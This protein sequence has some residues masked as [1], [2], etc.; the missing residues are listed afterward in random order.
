MS[1]RPRGRPPGSGGGPKK[2]TGGASKGR[3]KGSTK[4]ITEAHIR[5][6]PKIDTIFRK[7]AIVENRQNTI[8][9]MTVQNEKIRNRVLMEVEQNSKL[10][11][12][13]TRQTTFVTA[14]Q[15][16]VPVIERTIGVPYSFGGSGLAPTVTFFN[17][18][19]ARVNNTNVVSLNNKVQK[20]R[21]NTVLDA[22]NNTNIS[23][24]VI[25]DTIQSTVDRPSD[26]QLLSS[27]IND[28]QSA[29]MEMATL[30]VEEILANNPILADIIGNPQ[31]NLEAAMALLVEDIERTVSNTNLNSVVPEKKEL[32]V[33]AIEEDLEDQLNK[34]IPLLEEEREATNVFIPA[35]QSQNNNNN[36]RLIGVG[37]RSASQSQSQPQSQFNQLAFDLYLEHILENEQNMSSQRRLDINS[38]LS[39]SASQ[40]QSNGGG[41][42]GES[43]VFEVDFDYVNEYLTQMANNQ[44]EQEEEEK[45]KSIYLQETQI[46]E[47]SMTQ[48]P[49]INSYLSLPA[50]SPSPSSSPIPTVIRTTRFGIRRARPRGLGNRRR[51]RTTATTTSKGPRAIVEVGSET[52]ISRSSNDSM[53]V[54]RRRL[55]RL[56]SRTAA[57][58]VETDLRNSMQVEVELEDEYED[59]PAP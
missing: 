45:Q 58:S 26:A 25:D 6:T 59:E 16:V 8:E 54:L 20:R 39:Q 15:N 57:N 47:G 29:T 27:V 7:V 51:T 31:I 5:G 37:F 3:P 32:N 28:G 9:Q 35:S 21:I 13:N 36:N 14:P 1:G 34:P 48:L 18:L 49:I 30:N 56:T 24:I 53:Q 44:L 43:Q 2:I 33:D 46:V 52:L 50:P 55:R 23:S 41:Q 38:F 12:S 42:R 11:T 10:I 4:K 22:M 17:D 19:N 40:S